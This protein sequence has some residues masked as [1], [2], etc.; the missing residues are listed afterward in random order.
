MKDKAEKE[1]KKRQSRTTLIKPE[2]GNKQ[3]EDTLQEKEIKYGKLL[4][5]IQDGVYA[6]DIEGRMTYVNESV[7]KRTELPRE[8][9]R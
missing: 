7:V 9:T 5:S 3:G 8:F 4:E 6:M 1:K 2:T